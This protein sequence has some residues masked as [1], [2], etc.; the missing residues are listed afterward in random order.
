[1]GAS[2]MLAVA[3]KLLVAY[4]RRDEPALQSASQKTDELALQSGSQKTDG[5]HRALVVFAGQFR[6]FRAGMAAL[7]RELFLH[8]TDVA[9]D[10][11]VITDSKNVCS[12]KDRS[13]R[14]KRCVCAE[15]EISNSSVEQVIRQVSGDRRVRFVTLDEGRLCEAWGAQRPLGRLAEASYESFLLMR[16]DVHLSAPLNLRATCRAYPGFNIVSSNVTYCNAFHN[17]DV[18]LAYL[19]C[20]A[21]SLEAWFSV[22]HGVTHWPLGRTSAAD[23]CQEAIAAAG[24]RCPTTEPWE[25]SGS[26]EPTNCLAVDAQC[27]RAGEFRK[28]KLRMGNLDAARIFSV[29]LHPDGTSDDGT[30]L[31]SLASNCAALDA[32]P[33]AVERVQDASAPLV[34][35]TPGVDSRGVERTTRYRWSTQR[36]GA[37]G[38]EAWVGGTAEVVTDA[39]PSPATLT[40]VRGATKLATYQATGPPLNC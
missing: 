12:E 34:W 17:A 11:A 27:R 39:D 5:T 19:A 28:R 8:N 16:P 20:D 23:S 31:G 1:M 2:A 37:G 32:D 40:K 29:P 25:F 6:D 24:G 22:C 38:S 4:V 30:A 3:L 7:E 35:H 21:Q 26:W 36:F 15:A 9:I 33:T 14:P 10:L 18:D 13:K